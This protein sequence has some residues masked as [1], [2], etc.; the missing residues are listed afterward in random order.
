MY[1]VWY[2]IESTSELQ[3]GTFALF[4]N[5]QTCIFNDIVFVPELPHVDGHV[6]VGK[7]PIKIKPKKIQPWNFDQTNI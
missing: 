3:P 4:A 1:I 5:G 2:K 6:H 7:V